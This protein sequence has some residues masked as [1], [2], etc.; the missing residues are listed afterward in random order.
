MGVGKGK[1]EV[2][3]GGG[4]ESTEE[5]LSG[6]DSAESTPSRIMIFELR[7]SGTKS[8]TSLITRGQM[9][10]LLAVSSVAGGVASPPHPTLSCSPFFLQV[11]FLRISL[12][13]IKSVARLSQPPLC[14]P[15][16]LLRSVTDPRE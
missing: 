15:V 9:S 8:G 13:V 7:F 16:V 4:Q 12:K 2:E 11:F 1:E 14:G 3:G 5:G 6:S 10:S